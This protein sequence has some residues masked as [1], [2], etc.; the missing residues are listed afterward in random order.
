MLSQQELAEQARVKALGALAVLDTPQEDRFDRFTRLAS[1]ALDAPI[2]LVSLVD[3]DRQWFKSCIGLAIRE[4]PR[5]LAFCSHAIAL[6]DLLVVRDTLLDERFADNPLV[7]GEPG[8]RFYAGQPLHSVDGQPLGT[9]CILDKRP[10]EFG[11][12]ERRM[13]VDLARMVQDELNRTVLVESRDI[14]QQALRDLNAQLE[15]RVLDRTCEL[16]AK[17]AVL[18]QEIVRRQAAELGMLQKQELLDAVLETID[19]GVAACDG[20]G[21]LTLFNRAMRDMVQ[22]DAAP[23]LGADRWPAHYRVYDDSG[24]R[25]LD[26]D[27][28]PLVRALRG[29]KVVDAPLTIDAPGAGP[30]RLLASGRALQCVNGEALGAVV[31]LK[32]VTELAD[33]RA[34]VIESEEWLRTIADNVPALIAYIDTGLRYR[35]ANDRYREWM[36]VKSQDMIGKT[37]LEALGEAFYEPRRAALKR[38]LGGYASHLEIEEQR[39][40]RT[41][42]ISSTYLPH[43]RD[44]EVQGIYVMS[45]D[46]TS[47]R[48]YERQLHAL[49]HSDHLTGLPNRRSFDERLVQAIARSRRSA[50][51]LALVYLDVDHFKQVN[52]T[53]GHAVGDA[54]L[55]EF[56]RRLSATVRTTDT[57]ARL[58]GDEF[59]VVLEQVGSPLECERIAAKLLDAI[60]PAFDIDGHTLSITSSM[61]IAWCPRP[62]QG[63]MAHAADQALYQS[64]HAGRNT[65]SVMVVSG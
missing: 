16:H 30:R 22:A 3:A 34:R 2:A 61:G 38:C 33:S 64:K 57:V 63:A 58:A 59:V 54:V 18:E 28:Q 31:A 19:V 44:G 23:D 46:A 9:L 26:A 29:E 1:A 45:T 39:R 17:N 41:R 50:M 27:A 15:Q 14:A 43:V 60:R 47:A 24:K 42:V 13:L 5:S 52:D 12:A 32:D 36:G 53:L 20:E 37:V 25:L 56:G 49:A 10:R 62:E 55:R 4:T 48:E 40:G 7:V 6:D 8:V 11:P 35:F 65:A 21:R 51:P